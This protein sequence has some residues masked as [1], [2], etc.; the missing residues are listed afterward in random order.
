MARPVP[1]LPDVGSMIVPPGRSRP[2]RSAASTSRI[3]TRSLIDPPGLKYSTLATT[4]GASP[5]P[6]RLSRTSGVSP[7]V[8]R[9]ESLMSGSS[10]V[11]CVAMARMLRG[12]DLPGEMRLARA[13]VVDG[14][15]P[16]VLAEDDGR[17]QEQRQLE[18]HVHRVGLR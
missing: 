16:A 15:A 7:T 9:I 3:A 6:I 8:S 5:A 10:L 17:A 12:R 13:G 18:R 14:E 2:S 11:P 1:V 4:C